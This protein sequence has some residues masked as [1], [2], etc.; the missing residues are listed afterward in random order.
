MKIK[1]VFLYISAL[2]LGV[3]FGQLS[4]TLVGVLP[5]AVS[6]SSGLLYYDDTLITHNDSGNAP[7]L[8][9]LN[10]K[11]LK[12]EKEI[13]VVNAKNIDWED[14]AQD[15]NYI[16]VGDFGNYWGDREDLVVYKISKEAIK[17]SKKVSAEKIFYSY[18][19]KKDNKRKGSN[20]FDAEAMF[21]K[22]NELYILTKQWR[23]KKT[24]AYKIPVK[25]GKY[26]A[27]KVG[28]YNTK[29]L[30]TGATYNTKSNKVVLVG[31]N[32][33]MMPFVVE[34]NNSTNTNLFAG[35]TK[36]TQL[37]IGFVQMEGIAT[38]PN[39]GYYMSSESFTKLGASASI[40]KLDGK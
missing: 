39:G 13:E 21:Y 16:Y 34:V 12:I 9:Q 3:L 4:S 36:R 2:S 10:N 22:N 40:Y 11:T 8:Y 26:I 28:E 32:M 24:A 6:E 18:P 15:L 30:V 1:I 38:L 31:Y 35:V 14:L 20:D 33:F 23:G 25:P 29:G 19:D 37:D 7:I 27:T 17:T 5:D